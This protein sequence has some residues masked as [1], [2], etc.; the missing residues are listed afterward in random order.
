MMMGLGPLLL[1]FMLSL[2]QTPLTLAQNDSRY[3]HFV[4]QHHDANS[5][6]H[7]GSYC[8]TIMRRGGPTLLCKD[9][10][11]NIKVICEDENGMPYRKKIRISRFPFHVLLA[12]IKRDP[13]PPRQYRATSG[14]RDIVVA[15]EHGLPFDESLHCP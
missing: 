7:N 13:W 3:R 1:I 11:H 15:Y 4:A 6:G 12:G 9:T 5:N 2:G 8:E 10:S 14:S